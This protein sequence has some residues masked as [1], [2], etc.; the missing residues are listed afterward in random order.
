MV[1]KTNQTTYR[2]PVVALMGHIDHGKTSLL[3]YIRQS[4]LQNKEAGGI[5][6]RVSAY[7]VSVNG[8][9]ITFIDTPG[10]KV[11][12]KM[13]AWGA[14]VTDLVVLVI[15]ADEGIKTQTEEC[16]NH[17]KEVKVPFL[18]ALNKI[19][20]PNVNQEEIKNRLTQYGVVTEDRGGDI[21]LVPVSAKTG[22][23]VDEL[24]EMIVLVAQM[25]D[26]KTSPRA[27]FSGVV[28]ESLLDR[29]RGILTTVIVKQGRLLVGQ[30]IAS[31]KEK[32]KVR[33][34]FDDL[35]QRID[36]AVTSQ[37]VSILG[38]NN[39]LPAGSLV[40][41]VN[42]KINQPA[43]L[44]EDLLSTHDQG[45]LVKLVVKTDTQ[46]TLE[47]LLGSLPKEDLAIVRAGV[48]DISESDVFFAVSSGAEIIGFNIRASRSIMDL[49][50]SEGVIINIKKVIY[51]LIQLIEEK[52]EA[53]KAAKEEKQLLGEAQIVADFIV[54]EGRVAGARVI[55]GI[56]E[57]GTEVLVVRPG[58]WEKKTKIVSLRQE[59]K[60]VDQAKKGQEFGAIFSP[61]V[62]F[63]IGDMIK[64]RQLK[65]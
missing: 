64:Y 60:A 19:D 52:I 50:E 56:I 11:F 20:L 53:A 44:E 33:A 51:H 17:I 21:V 28:I 57:E 43:S 42:L 46:G 2:P 9:K 29:Q 32:I 14:R 40:Y 8:K 62:D 15:A 22:Q 59:K 27:P 5:T 39:L 41:D 35:G 36:Q 23:G 47:A 26:L 13:R 58:K 12:E 65:E 54:P 38:F 31:E 55:S 1:A 10:H 37:P 61:S 49:A 25:N 24:L 34:L 30:E 3:D 4:H 45:E 18:V 6:Q 48:G 63:N 16:L 7:Q